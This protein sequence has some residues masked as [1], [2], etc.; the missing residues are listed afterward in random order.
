VQYN[1]PN[2]VLVNPE[3]HPIS[4][5]PRRVQKPT[6][7]THWD[8]DQ[9]QVKS[10]AAKPLVKNRNAMKT[11]IDLQDAAKVAINPERYAREVFASLAFE[12]IQAKLGRVI[13][14]GSSNTFK[15]SNTTTTTTNTLNYYTS[16]PLNNSTT[17]G[18]SSSNKTLL[19]L[20]GTKDDQILQLR[21]HLALLQGDE[22]PNA[23]ATTYP[24]IISFHQEQAS[25]LN[26]IE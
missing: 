21:S 17:Q 20:S 10:K 22:A 13:H 7:P 23:L 9:Q 15:N 19:P 6:M 16:R 12:E 24:K 25:A 4:H 2:N 14:L 1:N 11:E 5:H 3:Y 18:T 8:V 26:A